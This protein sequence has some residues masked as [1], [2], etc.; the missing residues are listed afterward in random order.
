M[1][2]HNYPIINPP[3]L[4]SNT[5]ELRPKN[6]DLDLS[7]FVS[8]LKAMQTLP[9]AQ[10]ASREQT[11]AAKIWLRDIGKSSIDKHMGGAERPT[12]QL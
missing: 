6:I 8:S 12:V 4:V 10:G 1:N 2:Y 7:H 11:Y 3:I 5:D 9:C